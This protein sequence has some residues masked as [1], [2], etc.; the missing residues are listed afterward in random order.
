MKRPLEFIATGDD[1]SRKFEAF[2]DSF[3][4]RHPGIDILLKTGQEAAIPAL[5]IP[6]NIRLE[7]VPGDKWESV[8]TDFLKGNLSSLKNRH[9]VE[10]LN[11]RARIKLFIAPL[12]PFCPSVISNLLALA[13]DQPLLQLTIIDGE[14]F[15][16]KALADQVKAAPT[17]ILDDSVRWTGTVDMD[18]ILSIIRDRD[19]ASLSVESIKTLIENGAAEEV[20]R[21]MADSGRLFPA[22][23]DLLIHEKWPLRLGAMVAFE[24]LL[25]KDREL[26]DEV[27]E[28]LWVRFDKLDD[29]V[30]GDVLHLFGLVGGERAVEK[31]TTILNSPY[32]EEVLEAAKESLESAIST[33]LH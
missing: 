13:S 17:L 19:P 15:P 21:M 27:I 30:K 4:Q 18:E 11:T 12:C 29:G 31:L 25:E 24:Y 2:I 26:A 33:T 23:L 3:G 8:F 32:P 22:F 10:E 20:A 28:L 6:P 5:L 9:P 14:M 7:A 16:E 1:R